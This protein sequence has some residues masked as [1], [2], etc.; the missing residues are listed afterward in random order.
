MFKVTNVVTN[1]VEVVETKKEI[2]NIIVAANVTDNSV[3]TIEKKVGK[4]NVNDTDALLYETF[5]IEFI[6][7]DEVNMKNEEIVIAEEVQNEEIVYDNPADM[8]IEETP[9]SDDAVTS[10]TQNSEDEIIEE[11]EISVVNEDNAVDGEETTKTDE[12]QNETTT[13]EEPKKRVG[14]VLIAYENGVEIARFPSIKKCAEYFKDKMKLKH[15]PFTPIMKSARQDIDWNEYSFKFENEGDLH[16][17]ASLKKKIEES[18]KLAEQKS[19]E[20][21]VN[22][23]VEN[24]ETTSTE[25]QDEIIEE[26]VEEIIE[27]QAANA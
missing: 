8:Q 4:H 6:E 16:I 2:T 10:E 27:D 15:M 12:V 17:P 23:P 5:K 24:A 21:V 13:P 25:Q 9:K 18:Q 20:N 26:I 1:S 19:G 22:N 11:T 7:G 3:K 14:K